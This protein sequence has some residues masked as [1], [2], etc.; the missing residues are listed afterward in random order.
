MK[1]AGLYIHIPFCRAK[2]TYC[3]FYSVADR[4]EQIPGF[5]DALIQELN[6]T[7]INTTEW[8]IDTIFIGGGTP[9][10]LSPD[11]LQQILGVVQ[12]VFSID[13]WAEI[14]L[15]A[16]PGEA[17]G[18]KLIGFL[19]VGINRLS[20]GAQS[21]N[22]NALQ[23]LTRIHSAEDIF[24]TFESARNSGFENINC[25]MIYNIP[26]QSVDDW[27]K[28]LSKIIELSPEHISVY[29]LTVE[30]GTPLFKEI[31]SG[32]IKMPF[33]SVTMKMLRWANM[34][35]NNSGFRQYEISNYALQ[36]F[37]CKHNLH[38]WK[39]EP[40]FGFGP[41]AHSF[42]GEKRWSNISNLDQYVRSIRNNRSPIQHTSV[43][44]DL[45]LANEMIGF[46]MRMNAGISLNQLPFQYRSALSQ[47]INSLGSQ[48]A[49]MIIQESNRIRLS[50]R[51]MLYADALAVELMFD[52]D[53][54]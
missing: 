24:K 14:T 38:Y 31:H 47:K 2:C 37:E 34:H 46:G 50:E 13:S 53:D 49:G 15:E 26:G 36:G 35:L 17:P 23:F 45:T 51:G 25:D 6:N 5:I 20:I 40:Y 11:D 10:L 4:D 52:P 44:T 54:Q 33:E 18:N 42:D 28:D 9:S 12:K 48:W 43:I 27:K 29:S 8:I 32:R 16:N 22:K 21:F 41:S 19:E 39:I 3:D 7:K 30:K 1:R